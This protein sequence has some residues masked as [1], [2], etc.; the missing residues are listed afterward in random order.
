MVD[1]F[2]GSEQARR[3]LRRAVMIAANDPAATPVQKADALIA[4]ADLLNLKTDRWN[5]TVRRYR[6]AWDILTDAGLIAERDARFGRPSPLND[7]PDNTT[8]AFR[9]LLDSQANP[10]GLDGYVALRFDLSDR[11]KVRNVEVIE[12]RPRGYGDPIVKHHLE[13]LLFRPS[14]DSGEPVASEGHE[15]RFA[16]RYG[17]DDTALA[18]TTSARIEIDRESDVRTP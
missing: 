15:Y 18:S 13:T 16:F 7:V 12:T 10:N 4:F 5:S 11:G 14:F 3:Y 1:G 9:H 17:P 6:E 8:I 2:D